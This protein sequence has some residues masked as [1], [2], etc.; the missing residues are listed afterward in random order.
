VLGVTSPPRTLSPIVLAELDYLVGAWVGEIP[1]LSLLAEV[2]RGVYSVA[3]FSNDDVAAA[4]I[5][6][7]HYADLGVSLADASIVVLSERYGTRDVLTLDEP[8]PRPPRCA[9]PAVPRPSG[10]RL[11]CGLSG[12]TRTRRS[13][14]RRGGACR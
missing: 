10:R 2:G 5:V 1:R 9:R 4:W 12:R 11:I 3:P 14:A 13:S 7:E 8:L 6:M